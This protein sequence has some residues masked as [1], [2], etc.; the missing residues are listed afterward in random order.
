[1]KAYLKNKMTES[2]ITVNRKKTEGLSLEQEIEQLI[3]SKQPLQGGAT[4]IYTEKSKGVLPEYDIKTDRFDIAAETKHA[5]T[6]RA[7]MKPMEGGA[8]EEKG[9]ADENSAEQKS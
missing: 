9:K 1:M 3:K 7:I 4:M 6:R 5:A 8:N 2:I